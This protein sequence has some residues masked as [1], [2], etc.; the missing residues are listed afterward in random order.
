[1][2][3]HRTLCGGLGSGG[4][5]LLSAALLLLAAAVHV[6]GN[7]QN[8][9]YTW[10][11]IVKDC[12]QVINHG[13][14]YAAIGQHAPVRAM[15]G[16]AH[17]V[18]NLAGE[19]RQ[20]LH[21]WRNCDAAALAQQQHNGQL[22]NNQQQ[23][24]NGAVPNAA[25]CLQAWIAS[26]AG[27]PLN[28][29]QAQAQQMQ[30]GAPPAGWTHIPL[31]GQAPAHAGPP[32]RLISKVGITT[33]ASM[34]EARLKATERMHH[35]YGAMLSTMLRES[36]VC[37]AERP[38]LVAIAWIPHA[39]GAAASIEWRTHRA[40]SYFRMWR[41]EANAPVTQNACDMTQTVQQVE[42]GA[43]PARVG[44]SG[45]TELNAEH[46]PFAAE[47]MFYCTAKFLEHR[48]DT[49]WGALETWVA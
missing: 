7:E 37:S 36:N 39:A 46:G 9:L 5:R 6:N 42:A 14:P 26:I 19:F 44:P 41:G 33:A 35:Y 49:H 32:N 12:G 28:I 45:T 2:R 21:T 4:L 31:V 3:T 48:S 25:Q 24:Q 47:M 1:M 10:E 15:Q 13:V 43:A 29:P 34:Q 8:V 22:Q 11:T 30:P 16:E 27:P 17:R 23:Q 38:R 40:L 20:A 18:S